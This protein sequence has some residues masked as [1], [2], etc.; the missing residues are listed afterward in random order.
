[1]VGLFIEV[2]RELNKFP[3]DA[4]M[5]IKAR[6]SPGF[7]WP[8]T[9]AGKGSKRQLAERVLEHCAKHPGYEDVVALCAPVIQ[10]QQKTVELRAPPGSSVNIGFVY[11]MKS[12]KYYKIGRTNHLGGRERDLA[13][14]LPDKVSTIHSIRTDDPP[15]IEAY[16]HNR[17]ASKRKNGEWFELDTYDVAAFKRR[18]FM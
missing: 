17:F 18:K 5:K 7:P 11:L 14:Q 16:W 1:M 10:G 4:E 6:R 8:E 9:F 2:I 15:G 3:T 12:G 13:I